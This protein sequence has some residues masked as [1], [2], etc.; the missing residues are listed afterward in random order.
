MVREKEREKRCLKFG[1]I[2]IC[3]WKGY[4]V[5]KKKL[6]EFNFKI[7]FVEVYNF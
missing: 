2:W 7:K 1:I 4:V 5:F 6:K 3:R